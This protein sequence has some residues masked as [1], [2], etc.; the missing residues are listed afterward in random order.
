[1]LRRTRMIDPDFHLTSENAKATAELMVHLDGLPLAIKLAAS[2][3]QLLSPQMLLE[4]LSQRL[5]LL[6]WEALDLPKRQHTLKTA[7][8]WSYDLLSPNEQILFRSLSVFVGGFTLEAAEA[9]VAE[10]GSQTI[11]VLEVLGSLVDKSLVQREDDMQGS[12]RFRLLESVREFALEHLAEAGERDAA[13]RS[14][15]LY[16]VALAVRAEPELTGPGQRAWFLRLEEAQDNL[17]AALEWLLDQDD[18]EAALRLATALGHFWEVRGYLADGRRWLEAAL[19]R[20]SAAAPTLRAR[21]LI[22]LGAI[23]VLSVDRTGVNGIDE[24]GHAEEVLTEGMD[25]AR[26]SGDTVSIARALTF[27]GTLTLQTGEWD[28]GRHF[29]QEAQAYFQESGHDREIIQAILPRGVIAFLQGRDEEAMQLMDEILKR[30]QDVGDDWGRGVALLFA[31]SVTATRGDLT[32][33]SAMGQELLAITMQSHGDRLMYLST[34]GIAWLLRSHGHPERLARLVGAAE[35]MDQAIG[36]VRSLIENV[37]IAPTRD[38]LRARM[39]QE[40]LNAA[41]RAGHHQT[42]GQVGALIREVLEGALQ[43]NTHQGPGRE[44]THEGILSAREREVL[45]LIAEG[46]SNKQIAHELIIAESTVRY[47]LTSVFNKL[48]VD[49]RTHALSVAA[50]RGLIDLGSAL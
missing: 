23:L 8:A 41:L 6:R 2:R 45:Q 1:F 33:A 37:Y 35:S 30:Y 40:E 44:S 47:H 32:G 13:K 20:P 48:G 39:E 36:L 5:S 34:A 9:I 21:A 42:F 25:L 50:Q 12:Y 22:W 10:A 3:I 49:N 24:A 46:L 19:A 11:D 18:G 27:L 16:F 4:R 38:V 29:L 26:T 14:H 17:R 15:A 28:Q 7:I 43:E 31:M